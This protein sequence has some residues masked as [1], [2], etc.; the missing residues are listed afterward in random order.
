MTLDT[1]LRPPDPT[2]FTG[3]LVDR[4]SAVAGYLAAEEERQRS[5]LELIAPKNYMSRAVYEAH[6]SIACLT[7]IEGY[8][9]RRMHAGMINLDHIERL[10]IERA[11]ELFD[12]R[13]ANVQPHSGTQANQAVFFALLE[14][15]DA[16]LSLALK[17]GGHLSHGLRS[18]V[19]GRWFRVA[20]YGLRAETGLI[21]YDEVEGL[22]RRIRPRLI[23]T[24]GSSY[25]RSIDFARLR[26]IADSVRAYLLVDMAHIAGLVAAGVYAS[27]FPTPTW[28]PR[29][30]TR[31][32]GAAEAG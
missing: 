26:A 21:D 1:E 14:P 15:G 12:C 30:R 20:S 10:A 16:V 11:G 22:A 32:C 9:G 5:Q 4:D 18:N 28:S 13:Y 31:T 7:S 3:F 24:G 27:P 29:Q 23:I 8:P 25:P 2:T 17:A 19:S 6:S